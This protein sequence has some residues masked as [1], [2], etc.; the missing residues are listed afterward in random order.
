[1]SKEGAQGLKGGDQS[2]RATAH[3]LAEMLFFTPF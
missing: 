3:F 2:W 1:M